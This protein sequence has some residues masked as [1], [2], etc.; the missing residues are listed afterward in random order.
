MRQRVVIVVAVAAVVAVA[1]LVAVA[2]GGG[3]TIVNPGSSAVTGISV[4]GTGR[5]TAEPDLVLLQLGI[6]VERSTVAAARE[7]AAASQQAILD[8]LQ[9]NGVDEDDIQTVQLS[10]GTRYDYSSDNERVLRG[11]N[12]SNVVSITLRG[13]EG[14]SAVIDAAIAAGGN[15]VIVRDIAF[16]IED[17]TELREAARRD[18]VEDARERASQLAEAAG[19]KLGRPISIVESGFTPFQQRGDD[20][21]AFDQADTATPIQ[22][23]E[24]EILVRVNIL[25]AI[26]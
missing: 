19:I 18:A 16:A 8:A 25:Y 1:V 12:V 13:V 9:A 20:D 4:T 17:P 2:C 5:A 22:A 21:A 3:D 14:A 15:S 7:D 11:Y 10:V 24:L 23:G 6:E 26:E